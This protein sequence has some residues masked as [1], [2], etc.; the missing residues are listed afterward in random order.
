MLPLETIG[1]R[2][3]KWETFHKIW[4]KNSRAKVRREN[5]E[6]DENQFHEKFRENNFQKHLCICTFVFFPQ[7]ICHHR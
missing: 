6:E 7:S 3:R 5:G 1:L 4:F 2:N